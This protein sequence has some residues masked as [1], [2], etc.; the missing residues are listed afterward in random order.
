MDSRDQG[1]NM[2]GIA[3]EEKEKDSDRGE[4]AAWAGADGKLYMHVCVCVKYI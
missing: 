1:I 2:V 4:E 3:R